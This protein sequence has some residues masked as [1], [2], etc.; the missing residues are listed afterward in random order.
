MDITFGPAK[1]ARNIAERDLLFERVAEIDWETSI[2]EEDIRKDYGER[3]VRVFGFL[4]R[5][6][7]VTVITMRGET[8]HVISLRK[9]NEREVRRYGQTKA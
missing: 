4:D 8:I 5:R 2:S 6:L 7:H 3:R 9:A 1:N